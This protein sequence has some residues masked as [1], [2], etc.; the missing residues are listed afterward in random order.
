VSEKNAQQRLRIWRKWVTSWQQIEKEY[1]AALRTL[2]LRQQRELITK[3]DKAFNESKHLTPPTPLAGSVPLTDG[4]REKADTG[5]LI[6]RVVFDLKKENGKLKVL[7]NLFFE[8]AS[9]LG[10]AQTLSELQGLEGDA[11]KA[12]VKKVKLSPVMRQSLS[13]SSHK[14]QGVNRTTQT[15]VARQMQAGL[16]SGEG[17]NDLSKRIKK[18]LG[19]NRSRTLHI[20][21]TQTAGAVSTGRQAGMTSA[22]VELKS[23]LSSGD[24]VVRKAHR[25]AEGQHKDGIPI[26]QPFWVGGEALMFPADP[27]GTPGNIINCRCLQIAKKVNGKTL[28]LAF[29]DRVKFLDSTDLKTLLNEV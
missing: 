1:T 3:L 18:V 2:F 28:D 29:Y 14:I 20:A 10:A 21:R 23:W 17:L 16:E 27:H 5:D 25:D 6:A 24:T 22:G 15:R 7:N 4:D 9:A 11:L 12:A 8:K 26:D 13:V 19:D